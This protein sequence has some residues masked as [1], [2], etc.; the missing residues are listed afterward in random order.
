ME[1]GA[2][3]R[4]TA[5][6]MSRENIE[7]VR[8]GFEALNRGDLSGALQDSAADFV[9]DFSRSLSP[10]RGVYGREDIPR[11]RDVFVGHWESVRYEPEEPIEGDDQVITVF[12]MYMRGR[13]G[14]EVQTRNA[15]L[16]SFRNGQIGRITFFQERRDALEA[17]GLSE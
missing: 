5:G 10:E 17:A 3:S 2:S 11:F 15:W 8:R 13:D 9:F 12:T 6:V 14:I 1:S 4:D 7:I 16:W